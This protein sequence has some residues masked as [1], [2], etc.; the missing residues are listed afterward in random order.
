MLEQEA[1]EEIVGEAP[2]DGVEGVVVEAVQRVLYC[3]RHGSS[4]ARVARL[5]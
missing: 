4:I 3:R 1:A 2:D 5:H